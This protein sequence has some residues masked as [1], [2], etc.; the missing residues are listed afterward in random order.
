M[1][2][3]GNLIIVSG[4]SGVGKGSITE[5]V[6]NI[7]ENIS[8]SV[9]ATTRLPRKGEVDGKHYYFIDKE[10][11]LDRL[12]KGEFL[13][14]NEH[15]DNYYGTLKSEVDKF[16][17]QGKDVILDIEVVGAK[18]LKDSGVKA[19]FVFV[20]PPSLNELKRR[21]KNRG[22]ESEEMLEKR[23][24]RALMEVSYINHY[25]YYVINENLEQ[26]S[27]DLLNIIKVNRSRVNNEI[28]VV[29]DNIL[30]V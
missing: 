6:R 20:L 22:S 11:F 3:R 21:I 19:I 15:F 2:K 7:D 10:Q 28:N 29:I 26:S 16:L 18:K 8:F 13:E 25:D 27:N 23:I 9:S 1:N 14:Y 30:S 24:E 17:S 4:P 5:I 12:N